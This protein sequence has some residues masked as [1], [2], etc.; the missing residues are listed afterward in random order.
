M[1]YVENGIPY[2][3]I[4]GNIYMHY[5]CIANTKDYLF[6]MIP[7]SPRMRAGGLS[8]VDEVVTRERYKTSGRLT[9]LYFRVPRVFTPRFSGKGRSRHP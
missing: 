8:V 5:A 9:L 7:R 4:L 1:R 6:E 2:N 3:M